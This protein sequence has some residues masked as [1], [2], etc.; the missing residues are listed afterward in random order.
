MKINNNKKMRG[1]LEKHFSDPGLARG[2]QGQV[3]T[4]WVHL[5]VA[6]LGASGKT[7]LIRTR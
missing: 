2:T 7:E 6:A 3:S 5:V 4:L 1:I